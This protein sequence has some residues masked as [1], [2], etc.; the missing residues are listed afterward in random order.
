MHVTVKLYGE[1]RRYRPAS[2]EGAPHHPFSVQV[3]AAA[4][5]STLLN[6]LKIPP[7]LINAAAVNKEAV[8]VDSTLQPDDEVALFPP[9]AGGG[10]PSPSQP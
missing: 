5:I 3:P 8:P 7:D 1:L 2:A 10:H 9:T 4:T 6:A